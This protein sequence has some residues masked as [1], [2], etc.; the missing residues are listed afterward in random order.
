L[1]P[2]DRLVLRFAGGG[3]YGDPRRRDRQAVR[4]DVRNGYVSPEA[5]Q[6]DYGLSG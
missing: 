5:A 3:G 6:R 4:D 1:K 2:G